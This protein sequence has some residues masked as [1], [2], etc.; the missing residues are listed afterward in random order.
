MFYF[1]RSVSG[2][3]EA[4]K[5]D[6]GHH[7]IN[8]FRFSRNRI[9]LV[10]LIRSSFSDHCKHL[11]SYTAATK[12]SNHE[13]RDIRG[14]AEKFIW[15]RY[16]HCEW[17]FLSMGFKHCNT[18]GRRVWISK[19]TMLKKLIVTFNESILVSLWNFQLTIVYILAFTEQSHPCLRWVTSSGPRQHLVTSVRSARFKVTC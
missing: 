17:R 18:E 10:S 11:S 5:M 1:L 16:I 15:W 8:L 7:M 14:W 2:D 19:G 12:R 3:V 13:I 4:G 9:L 6:N